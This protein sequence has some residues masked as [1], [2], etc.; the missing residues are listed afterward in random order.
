MPSPGR[1][2]RSSD[3]PTAG[4]FAATGTMSTPRWWHVAT[5]LDTGEVLVAGGASASTS[6][7]SIWILAASAELY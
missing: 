7:G 5:L 1:R 2:A 4:T 6:G 3:D